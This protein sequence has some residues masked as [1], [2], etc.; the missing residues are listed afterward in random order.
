M[1]AGHERVPV[2]D[3]VVVVHA[4]NA[5]GKLLEA[6]RQ[7][8]LRTLADNEGDIFH[9][10]SCVPHFAPACKKGGALM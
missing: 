2:Q 4:A 5:Y 1:M 7:S 6:L 9:V 10:K 3:E 8:F